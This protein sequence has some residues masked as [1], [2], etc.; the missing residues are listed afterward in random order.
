MDVHLTIRSHLGL[1]RDVRITAPEGAILDQ[2]IVELAGTGDEPRLWDGPRSLPGFSMLGGPGLRQGSIV[3]IGA[4]GAPDLTLGSVLLLHVVGGP[5]AGRVLPLPRGTATVGRARGCDVRLQDPDVSREHAAITVTSAGIS[6]RDLGS[7]NGTTLEGAQV[8]SSDTPLSRSAYLRVGLSTLALAATPEPAA[9]LG[10]GP[11]GTRLVNRPPRTR[12]GPDT[13]G[14]LELDVE[15]ATRRLP[16]IQWFAA[17]LPALAGAILALLMH[18]PQ[19]LAFALLAPVVILGTALGERLN[20]RRSGKR[21]RRSRRVRTQAFELERTRQLRLETTARRIAHPDPAAILRIAQTPEY[22]LWERRR[23]DDD[24]LDVRLGLGDQPSRLLLRR[25]NAA[26]AA[27]VLCAVPVVIGLKAGPLGLDGPRDITLG[28]ARWLVGH[29]AALH[30]PVDVELALLLSEGNSTAWNWMR[31]LPHLGTRVA[32]DARTREELLSQLIAMLDQ[33]RSERPAS[34]GNRSATSDWPGRWLILV[35]EQCG[36]LTSLPGLARLLAEGPSVGI[37]AICLDSE[38]RQ[39]PGACTSL[40]S[41]SGETGSAAKVEGAAGRLLADFIIDRVEPRWADT[42]A[43]SLANLVDAATDSAA[44]LPERCR[45]VQLLGPSCLDPSSV[46]AHWR[47]GGT[48]TATIGVGPDSAFT[49]DLVRDGPHALV[50]GTTGAGKSE[51]LQTLIAGL[52]ANNAPADL[53]FVLVDYKGGSAF[54][55]CARLPH[56]SGLVTDLDAHLTA[57]ALQS[58]NAELRRRELLFAAAGAADLD[59]YR[60]GSA[61]AAHPLGRLVLVVD[62][63][64]ALAVELPDFVTGLVAIAQRGRS[65]G[66]HLV[67]ATQ[68]PGGV[69]SPEIRANTTLRISLRVTDTSES[70]D[71]IGSDAAAAIDKAIPGRAFVRTGASLSEIQVARINVAVAPGAGRRPTKG[72]RTRLLGTGPPT[73]VS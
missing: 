15:P 28:V 34:S 43:R 35:I 61:H 54:A 57:R 1:D 4:P 59:A 69:I 44:A 53:A 29:L 55:D 20:N 33:R 64:A 13:A 51:L 37:T 38:R 47:H 14:E 6:V 58:L 30:S 25:G 46:L 27:G 66:V 21:E 63:F 10:T 68:R 42:V 65:L 36:T 19:F 8:A 22:R 60:H 17:L 23:A 62:E 50:A 39:L 71:V 24:F 45:L 56:V 31:W 67:L 40:V 3:S 5:D 49:I 9:S 7:T 26:S 52:A 72:G 32:D 48:P 12:V 70:L 18:N 41:I 73:P 11:S 16:G 2:F